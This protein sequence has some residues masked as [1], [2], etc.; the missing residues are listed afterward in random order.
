MRVAYSRR[1]CEAQ[2]IVVPAP[3]TGVNVK[4]SVEIRYWNVNEL[5]VCNGSTGM[6]RMAVPNQGPS[7]V[8]NT[9]AVRNRLLLPNAMRGLSNQRFD[10]KP[11]CCGLKS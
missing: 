8:A 4:W 2:Y 10:P 1:S 11:I 5:P 9:L 6:R 7:W 3:D